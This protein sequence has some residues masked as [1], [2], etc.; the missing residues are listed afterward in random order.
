MTT[1]VT[2]N[3]TRANHQRASIRHHL[4]T[5][6]HLSILNHRNSRNTLESTMKKA[7][8][9]TSKYTTFQRKIF[10][11]GKITFS[12]YSTPLTLPYYATPLEYSIQNPEIYPIWIR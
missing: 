9:M 3:S 11:F 6:S 1:R 7:R 2:L 12:L 8:V 4:D 10:S 5:R